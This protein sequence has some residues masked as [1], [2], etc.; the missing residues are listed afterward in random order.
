M[1]KKYID[2]SDQ[3][4]KQKSCYKGL[5]FRDLCWSKMY[6]SGTP[7]LVVAIAVNGKV[8]VVILLKVVIVAGTG[9]IL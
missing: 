8:N 7:G 6:E 9:H 4:L 1:K 5:H 3:T 2:I